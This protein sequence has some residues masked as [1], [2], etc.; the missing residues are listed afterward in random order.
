MS[1]TSGGERAPRRLT[2]SVAV[3][4]VPMR[5]P[6]GLGPWLERA[7][8]RAARGAVD[9]AIISS[10]A[11]RRLNGRYRKLDKTTDVLS[12]PS[13]GVRPARVAQTHLGDI[14]I[15]AEVARRQAADHGHSLATEYRILALHGLLHLLGY[16]HERDAGQMKRLEERLRRRAGL[17]R[18][19]IARAGRSGHTP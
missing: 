16:D 8:P 11:M 19:L 5:A 6:A 3:L 17:A 9:I 18:G 12:F 4:G 14:A 1:R 2:V 13:G 10:R 7:A 15:A